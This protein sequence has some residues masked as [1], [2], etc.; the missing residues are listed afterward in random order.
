MCRPSYPIAM[1]LYSNHETALA[2]YG[3]IEEQ[4]SRSPSRVE[5]VFG[6]SFGEST[7]SGE[8]DFGFEPFGFGGFDSEISSEE[9]T[10]H[11]KCAVILFDEAHDGILVSDMRHGQRY[12]RFSEGHVAEAGVPQLISRIMKLAGEEYQWMS[13]LGPQ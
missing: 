7:H 10:R 6:G 11:Y 13:F 12:F 8:P 3:P 9:R 1:V 2:A 4:E 5:D